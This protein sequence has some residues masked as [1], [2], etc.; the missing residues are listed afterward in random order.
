MP[1]PDSASRYY[2]RQERLRYATLAAIL[3][4]WRRIQ[5]N[6]NWEQQYREDVG[7]K[8]LALIAAAQIAA[9]TEAN[10]YIPAVLTELGIAPEGPSVPRAAFVGLA[11]DGRPVETLLAQSVAVAG[12]TYA[13]LRDEAEAPVAVEGSLRVIPAAPAF[14]PDVAARDALAS[15]EQWMAMV[16]GTILSDTARAAESANTAARRQV[17]GYV[18]MLNPP[19][20]SRCAIL[21]GKFYRWNTGFL[22]HPRCDCRHIPASEAIAG[23]LTTSVDTYFDSLSPT[24]QD[25]IFTHKGAEAIRDGADINQ[26]VNARRGMSKAQIYGH[27][28]LVTTEG[29]TRRG[30]AYRSLNARLGTDSDLRAAGERYART[31]RVRLMPESIYEIAKD[32]D[33]AIRLLRLNGFIT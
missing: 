32:R 11:G 10:S 20:C 6:A 12:A 22:R 25:R 5:P 21:A 7:P 24:E 15:A 29:T 26:V 2:R 14:D 30:L 8:I 31:S 23:D 19:S 13:R 27:E 33:D 28:V 17:G 1:A 9:T 18:R 4:A 3:A 16:A